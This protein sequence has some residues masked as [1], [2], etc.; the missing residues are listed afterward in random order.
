M[1]LSDLTLSFAKG[2]GGPAVVLRP[3]RSEEKLKRAAAI[4]PF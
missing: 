3:I 1:I 2:K 4:L